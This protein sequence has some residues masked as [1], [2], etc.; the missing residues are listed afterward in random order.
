MN[1]TVWKFIKQNWLP[2]ALQAPQATYTLTGYGVVLGGIMG[3]LSDAAWA[4]LRVNEGKGVKVI[5]PPPTDPLGK[6]LR[7]LTEPSPHVA[8]GAVLSYED[9]WLLLAADVISMGLVME[10]FSPAALLEREEFYSSS[11]VLEYEPWKPESRVALSELGWRPGMTS[12]PAISGLSERPTYLEV[13]RRLAA[14][15]P[16]WVAEIARDF[17]ATYSATWFGVVFNELGAAVLNWLSETPGNVRPVFDADEMAVARLFEFGVKP[18][19]FVEGDSWLLYTERARELAAAAG[20]DFP[21][22]VEVKAAAVD[23]WGSYGSL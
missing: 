9:H 20:R 13:S 6:A 2:F 1:T 19:A 14:D 7:Y 5:G 18:P 3:A 4:L 10:N 15:L 22:P 12:A 21:G 17:P 11:E 8:G 23:S 16:R